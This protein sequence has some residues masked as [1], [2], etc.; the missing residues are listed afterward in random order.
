MEKISLKKTIDEIENQNTSL[1]K[2]VNKIYKDYSKLESILPFKFAELEA[3]NK[4]I[5]KMFYEF[6]IGK[7]SNSYEFK[8]TD[9][10]LVKIINFNV[11]LLVNECVLFVEDMVYNNPV[12]FKM[13]FHTI[14]NKVIEVE[15]IPYEFRG[16]YIEEVKFMNG[17]KLSLFRSVNNEKQEYYD[18][19]TS[20]V[21]SQYK[22]SDID[23]TEIIREDGY[24]EF[25]TNHRKDK[26]LCKYTP[27]SSEFIKSIGERITSVNLIMDKRLDRRIALKTS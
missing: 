14:D 1:K 13:A 17:Q 10:E 18:I 19:T 5:D 15:M 16:E 25:K 3:Q 9:D 24:I 4:V 26:V 2:E 12:R 21:G 22:K 7:N 27:I 8:N 11:P 23:Y 6:N 20:N